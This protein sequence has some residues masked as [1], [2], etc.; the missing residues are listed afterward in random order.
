[1]ISYAIHKCYLKWFLK[2]YFLSS[3][4]NNGFP[5]LSRVAPVILIFLPFAIQKI[6]P[7]YEFSGQF[8]VEPVLLIL[9]P[10]SITAIKKP[11]KA[12]FLFFSSNNGFPGQSRVEP[13]ILIL[14]L[15]AIMA[16]KM[17]LIAYFLFLLSSN[18]FFLINLKLH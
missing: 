16:M 9:V 5:G 3:F 7:N 13:V 4:S 12:K 10:F 6:V 11:N 17:L 14:V 2:A 18:V 8:G 1:M 15:L